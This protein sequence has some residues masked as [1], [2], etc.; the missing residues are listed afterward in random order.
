MRIGAMPAELS[1][2]TLSKLPTDAVEHRT[3]CGEM[4][5]KFCG[6]IFAENNFRAWRAG[7]DVEG[8]KLKFDDEFAQ[9]LYKRR[10]LPPTFSGFALRGNHRAAGKENSPRHRSFGQRDGL[11]Q[12]FG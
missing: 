9:R 11:A 12:A 4:R 7:A 2:E 5:L 1:D 3:V 10:P 6:R 8:E